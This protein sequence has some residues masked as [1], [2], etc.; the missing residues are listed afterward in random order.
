MGRWWRHW[1]GGWQ[2]QDWRIKCCGSCGEQRCHSFHQSKDA[3]FKP[4]LV[5]FVGLQVWL[6]T[7]R[8]RPCVLRAKQ[9]ADEEDGTCESEAGAGMG[10]G[11]REDESEGQGSCMAIS[12][13]A[14][15]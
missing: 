8:S 2:A 14:G 5:V 15:T 4:T 6:R 1:S 12:A 13:G 11:D 10:V 9:G 3:C 7:H